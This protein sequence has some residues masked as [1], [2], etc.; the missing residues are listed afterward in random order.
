LRA[1]CL[2]ISAGWVK[3]QYGWADSFQGSI[4]AD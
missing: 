4:V 2:A 3:S 1:L